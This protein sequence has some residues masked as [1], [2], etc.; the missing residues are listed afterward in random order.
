MNYLTK[1][2]PN[3]TPAQTD[4]FNQ[5]KPLYESWNQKIN[6]ISRKDIDNL[7]IRHILHSLALTKVVAFNPG[8]QIL[9]LGTGGGFPGIPLAIFYPE[10]QFKL[11]DGTRKKITV[12]QEITRA[13]G[14]KNVHAEQVRAEELKKERFDFVVCR[15]VASLDKLNE[16]SKRLIKQ[17]Q[18][19]VLPN[20]LLTLKGGNIRPEIKALPKGEY[21]EVYPISDYFDEEVFK[22]KY[23]IYVQG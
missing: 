5:L 16:W 23:I 2:F 4:L 8:A 21:T 11:I 9:D 15:A 3:L 10:V 18:T 22:E 7:E 12:V 13:L 14:L 17:K 19:H 20:G 1:Y 6:V